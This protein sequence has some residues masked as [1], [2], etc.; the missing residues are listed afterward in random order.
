MDD[1][2]DFK[3]SDD[4]LSVLGLLACEELLAEDQ[5]LDDAIIWEKYE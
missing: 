3:S 2:L 1:E 5:D 4:E